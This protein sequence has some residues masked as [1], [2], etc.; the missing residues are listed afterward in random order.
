MANLKSIAI[1]V[2]FAI[3]SFDA[4]ANLL[5]NSGFEDDL[6]NWSILGTARIRASDPAP[7][8]GTSYL[9]G[10]GSQFT[11]WQD[12]DLLDNGYSVSDLD[13]GMLTLQYG[14]WR[15]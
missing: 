2:T 13:A 10:R 1:S 5:V 4:N 3:A 9:Y 11:V 6:N 15:P 8:E 12:V 7:Y 14:G